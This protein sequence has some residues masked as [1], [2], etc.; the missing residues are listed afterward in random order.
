MTINKSSVF[1][2]MAI[3]AKAPP[4]ANEP[5]SPINT[6]AGFALKYKNPKQTALTTIPKK[7]TLKEPTNNPT[8][9][10]VAP[11]IAEIPVANPSKP[12]VKLTAFVVPKIMINANI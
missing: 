6:F 9:A 11:A 10:K 5:V 1:V 12:S 8:T 4:N 2:A 3:P 7:V